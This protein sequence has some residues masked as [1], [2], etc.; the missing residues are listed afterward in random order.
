M[1]SSDLR[2]TSANCEVKCFD[3]SA[4]QYLVMGALIAAGLDGVKRNL[5]L[6]AEFPDDP[7][8]HPEDELAEKGVKRLPMSLGDSLERLEADAVLKEAMGSMLFGA[9]AAVRRAELE[10]FAEM[11]PDAVAAAHR[12]RY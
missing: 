7:A 4:N 6:P 11:D 10:F 2:D 12:W 8:S 1:C 3:S 9:F 5:R